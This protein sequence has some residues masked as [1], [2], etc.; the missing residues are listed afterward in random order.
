MAAGNGTALDVCDSPCER[1]A[2]TVVLVLGD[3]T[4]RR[5]RG[6]GRER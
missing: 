1:R 4:P 5:P 3:G 2:A 6:P